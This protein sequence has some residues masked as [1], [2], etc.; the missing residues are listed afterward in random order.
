MKRIALCAV[1]FSCLFVNTQ[2]AEA[3]EFSLGSEVFCTKNW[4]GVSGGTAIMYPG[5]EI[6][7]QVPVVGYDPFYHSGQYRVTNG[8]MARGLWVWGGINVAMGLGLMN[9]LTINEDVVELNVHPQIGLIYRVTETVKIKKGRDIVIVLA[10]LKLLVG[11]GLV[12]QWDRWAGGSS[13]T[14]GGWSAVL[15]FDIPLN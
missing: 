4:C 7:L 9:M 15:G 11:G 10:R 6:D 12:F 14:E 1:L 13:R 3:A 8:L 5:L 2:L